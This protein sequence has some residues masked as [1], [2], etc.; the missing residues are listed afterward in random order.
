MFRE[1]CVDQSI[2]DLG[3]LL[4]VSP[5]PDNRLFRAMSAALTAVLLNAVKLRLDEPLEY[6]D[7][8]RA[9]LEKQEA[10]SWLV[11][12]G[13]MV[14]LIEQARVARQIQQGDSLAA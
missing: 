6:S 9:A 7:L 1:D 2:Q 14:A 3:D 11:N 4:S 8:V 12:L 13:G 5:S 10:S